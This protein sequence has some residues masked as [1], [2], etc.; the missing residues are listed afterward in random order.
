MLKIDLKNR[1]LEP[2]L[3]QSLIEAGITEKPDLQS[4]IERSPKAFFDEIDLGNAVLLGTEVRPASSMVENRIDLLALD[5]D[6]TVCVIELKRGSN[7]LHLLQAIAYAAMIAKWQPDQFREFLSEERFQEIQQSLG[8]GARINGA[9]R[10][11]LVA[12]AFEYEVLI[13]AEWLLEKYGLEILCVRLKVAKD[14]GSKALYLICEQVYPPL[15]VEDQVRSRKRGGSRQPP[16]SAK[17]S[18][19]I[20][21]NA[22]A[23]FLKE[24]RAVAAKSAD[25]VY[26]VEKNRSRHLKY[27]VGKKVAW[28]VN[29]HRLYASVWQYRR[30]SGDLE[31]WRK[32]LSQPA[33]V[34]E[35]DNRHALSF[36]LESKSDFD[37]FLA[38][39][40]EAST[41]QW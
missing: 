20:T 1:T 27:V 4:W 22:L 38:A 35:R 8:D 26:F 3:S 6:G 40:N 37:G 12:E 36:R 14:P 23:E 18:Q 13:T 16:S 21:N 34:G 15:E 32:R 29:I 17:S 7:K 10:I 39:V 5:E 25:T 9:Q 31:Y 41:F 24:Q 33:R 19:V 11:I 30:F 28:S 2:T